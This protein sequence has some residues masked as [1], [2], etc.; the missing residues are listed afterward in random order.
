MLSWVGKDVF[1]DTVYQQSGEVGS[2]ILSWRCLCKKAFLTSN[3]LIGH[4]RIT[5]NNTLI[6]VTLTIVLKV[7]SKSMPSSWEYSFATSLTLY[8]S[9]VPLYFNILKNHFGANYIHAFR[10]WYQYPSLIFIKSII[11]D[12]HGFILT[13]TCWCLSQCGWLYAQFL[14]H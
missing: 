8:L 9:I 4:C 13:R 14:F 12:L 11:F 5:Y 7:S 2:W 10:S 1:L 6:M 3:C